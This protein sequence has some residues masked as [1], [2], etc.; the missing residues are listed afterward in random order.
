MEIF[1]SLLFIYLLF[2]GFLGRGVATVAR[3]LVGLL[4]FAVFASVLPNVWWF[5]G[6]LAVY[7]IAMVLY[8]LL[9]DKTPPLTQIPLQSNLIAPD[10]NIISVDV[11]VTSDAQKQIKSFFDNR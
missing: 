9:S 2:S 1:L 8:Y 3:W 11:S 10:K 7:L 6:A 5:I 4:A